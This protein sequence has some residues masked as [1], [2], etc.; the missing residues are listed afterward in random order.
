[1]VG[2]VYRVEF[3][4]RAPIEF[5]RLGAARDLAQGPPPEPPAPATS[6]G[7]TARTATEDPGPQ[8]PEAE[9]AGPAIIPGEP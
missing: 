3:E 1:V 5:D 8:E 7:E 9:K 6:D 4:G 2:V